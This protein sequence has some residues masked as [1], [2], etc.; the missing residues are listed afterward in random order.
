MRWQKERKG[1]IIAYRRQLRLQKGSRISNIRH[2]KQQ[3]VLEATKY[4][5][6]QRKSMKMT[7]KNVAESAML[8]GKRSEKAT[9]SL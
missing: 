7:C 9:E 2:Q 3:N 5:K 4:Y 1:S 6:M 8:G